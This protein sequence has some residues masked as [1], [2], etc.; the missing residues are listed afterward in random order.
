MKTLP[1]SL[2]TVALI[3]PTIATTN[4]KAQDLS[5]VPLRDRQSPTFQ[6]LKPIASPFFIAQAGF[7]SLD[8]ASFFDS[9][10]LR[11]EDQ[12]RFRR[13]PS[14]VPPVRSQS[15][16]WQFVIFKE[17]G[18]SFW[19]PPGILSDE[20]VTLKTTVGEVKFR[21]LTTHSEDRRYVAAYASTLS[22][23]QVQSPE[24]LLNAIR[25]RVAPADKFKLTGDRVI[26]LD[27]Y[28]GRELSF[29]SKESS[30]TFRVYI[31]GKRAYVLG[32]IYPNA[33]P[34]PRSTRAFLN[35]FELLNP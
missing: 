23:Q 31:V 18:F 8:A 21:T 3:F 14:G 5:S 22:E 10:R 12:L 33:N 26:K 17:G 13:P 35:A 7:S 15:Q 1:L 28:P 9:G 2:L 4:G 6:T 29:S 24:Q 11:S 20:I 19:V 34:Q 32:V 25:D 27:K 30:I 16:G